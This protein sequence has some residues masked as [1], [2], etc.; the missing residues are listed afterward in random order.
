MGTL[1]GQTGK[2]CW[3]STQLVKLDQIH[4]GVRRKSIP[5]ISCCLVN[6]K[7]DG[8]VEHKVLACKFSSSPEEK[9]RG[10]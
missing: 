7:Q 4:N 5:S 9:F 1:K 3:T 6:K 2:F 8:G 10:S